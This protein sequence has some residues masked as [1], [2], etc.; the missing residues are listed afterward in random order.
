[1][2]SEGGSPF[3]P[4]SHHQGRG[5]APRAKRVKGKWDQ[6]EG[7]LPLR[8]HTSS[9]HLRVTQR[10]APLTSPNTADLV[11]SLRIKEKLWMRCYKATE[12]G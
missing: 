11:L 7:P 3:C 6:A 1:M 12:D 4:G 5:P 10:D 9:R 8:G 2:T